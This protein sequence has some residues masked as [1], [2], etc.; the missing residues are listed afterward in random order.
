MVKFAEDF[1]H[2]EF[3]KRSLPQILLD[4]FLPTLS[5]VRISYFKVGS[6]SVVALENNVTKSISVFALGLRLVGS[7]L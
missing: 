5:L 6:N 7:L 1:D 4:P 3:S 2:F